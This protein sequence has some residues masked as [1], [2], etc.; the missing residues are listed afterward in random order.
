VSQEAAAESRILIVDDDP[1]MIR[2]L[3]QAL[4]GIGKVYFTTRANDAYPIAQSVVPDLILLDIEMPEKDGFDVCQELRLDPALEG[5]PI[6]YVTGHTDAA[7]EALA[8][9]CGAID[10]ITKPPHI[11]V[12]KARVKNYLSLKHQSDQLR[13]L[14]MMDGLTGIANRRALDKALLQEWRR[15]CRNRNP[16]TLLMIDVDHFKAYNDTHGHLVGD[17]CLKAIA[18]TLARA[19]NR[20]GDL[21]AR[22]G[23]EEFV[24]LL[25]DCPQEKGEGIAEQVRADV[26]SLRVVDE[27]ARPLPSVTISIGLANGE[28]LCARATH[29][30]RQHESAVA[31][32]DCGVEPKMLLMAAD[33]ALYQA[34]E[35]GRNRVVKFTPDEG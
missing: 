24:L 23:G 33:R 22:Y 31:Y 11:E 16:M 34:K 35:R 15:A 2:V 5:V 7:T 27:E 12:V 21:V 8:L 25:P 32:P 29:C 1:Q 19:V 20:P 6:L 14:S 3:S 17:A 28:Q 4:K 18:T 13:S 9:S 10:F 30:W 26:E